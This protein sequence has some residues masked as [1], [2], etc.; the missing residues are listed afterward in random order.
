MMASK[1]EDTPQYEELPLSTNNPVVSSSDDPPIEFDPDL[2]E[3][4]N[5]ADVQVEDS[6]DSI[7]TFTVSSDVYA[8]QEE[9]ERLLNGSKRYILNQA[10]TASSY[11]SDEN[12]VGTG[13][14]LRT[15]S[16]GGPDVVLK[17]FVENKVMGG[18]VSSFSA[19]P[20]LV[21]NIPVEVEAVGEIFPQS[22]NRRYARPVRS[23]VSISHPDV[24]AGTLGCLVVLNNN[25]LCILSNNHVIAN[26][27]RAALRDPI[28]QPGKADGGTLP[29]DRIGALER[30]VPINFL[31]EN[32][33]D[34]AAAWTAFSLVD[35]RHITYTL[36]P[37]PTTARLGMTVKK[38]G[39]TTEHTIGIVTVVAANISVNY[40]IGIARFTNQVGIRGIGRQ[41]FSR[42]GDSGSLIVT[43]ATNQ[44]VALLFAGNNVDTTFANPIESVIRALGIR[45]FLDM[46]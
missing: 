46:R 15:D 9:L 5:S 45:R 23:G 18:S 12:I 37:T 13:I 41:P 26:N 7:D 39:R 6:P 36:N 31:G 32:Q 10:L 38:C 8:A 25:R 17:V 22:Y 19:V 16:G 29:A 21:G 11:D 33:V 27:N 35:P 42:G 40:G 3:G 20:T 30:F 14:G 43:V 4:A 24:T 2:V 1:R 34:A 28:L 44:P